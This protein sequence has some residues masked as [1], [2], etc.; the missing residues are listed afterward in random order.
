VLGF[1]HPGVAIDGR[2]LPEA[3]VRVEVPG[4]G[5]LVVEVWRGKALW[6]AMAS[7]QLFAAGTDRPNGTEQPLETGRGAGRVEFPHVALGRTYRV[8]PA[9]HGMRLDPQEGAGPA[10]PGDVAT[11]RFVA[12]DD[13]PLLRARL[14]NEDGAPKAHQLVIVNLEVQGHNRTY[15]TS[16]D[17]MGIIEQPLEDSFVGSLLSSV[18]VACTTAGRNNGSMALCD[19]RQA[20]PQGMLD[21]GDLVLRP[22]PILA[23]GILVDDVGTALRRPLKIR[24][25]GASLGGTGPQLHFAWRFGDRGTFAVRGL[26]A[27]ENLVFSGRWQDFQPVDHPFRRG[28]SDLH[29]V[30]QRRPRLAVIVQHDLPVEATRLLELTA[31]NEATGL[32]DTGAGG[33]EALAHDRIRLMLEMASAGRYTVEVR[34]ETDLTPL[35]TLRGVLAGDS[36][37]QEVD[38]RGKVRIARLT[39]VDSAGEPVRA[40]AL[41]VLRDAASVVTLSGRGGQLLVPL[42]TAPLAGT[43][44]VG[45]YRD[46][47]LSG[48][49]GDRTVQ[50]H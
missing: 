7:V 4:T 40:A 6:R 22:A 19:P 5:R 34:L 36:P 9:L 35:A 3:A 44:R 17:G 49:D 23:A 28:A 31:R 37:P 21:L 18:V 45:G 48:I 15:H 47:E 11:F 24:P 39:L 41:L 20:V 27:A 33:S 38:V 50:L 1:D 2:D 26:L 46:A 32:T 12:K 16:T 10:R 30:V 14:L 13:H 42:V 29:I 43:L 8:V 25:D